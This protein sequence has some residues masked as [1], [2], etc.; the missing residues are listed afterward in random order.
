MECQKRFGSEKPE[1]RTSSQ[2]NNK[3]TSK[4]VYFYH[5]ENKK[6]RL[7]AK[8]ELATLFWTK[9]LRN[10]AEEKNNNKKNMSN[11]FTLSL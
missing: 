11:S 3:T 10:G 2:K 1:K 6:S 7:E 8:P 5:S 9:F 4:N